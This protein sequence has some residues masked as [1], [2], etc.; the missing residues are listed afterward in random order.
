[1]GDS[2]FFKVDDDI[3]QAMFSHKFENI[4]VFHVSEH[5]Y[6]TLYKAERMGKWFMLKALK[7]EFA[8]SQLY[9][10][11]LYKEFEIGYN[12]SHPNIV[13]TLGM[14]N[15]PECGGACI[16]LEYIDGFNLRDYMTHGDKLTDETC[17]NII[18]EMSRALE[19]IHERQIIHRDLKPE[20][21]LITANGH[22]VKLI[23]FGFADVD[24]YSVLKASAGTRKYAAPEQLM[25]GAVVDSRAD[26][27]ALGLIMQEL[28]Q[29]VPALGKVARRCCNVNPARRPQRARYVPL[30]V[31]RLRWRRWLRAIAFAV[32][33]PVVIAITLYLIFSNNVKHSMQ[34]VVEDKT[35][36]GDTLRLSQ[37][38]DSAFDSRIDTPLT[39][40]PIKET[41][42]VSAGNLHPVDSVIGRVPSAEE[43]LGK[44]YA[45]TEYPYADDP[46][47]GSARSDATQQVIP[48]VCEYVLDVVRQISEAGNV[49]ELEQVLAKCKAQG[50][51]RAQLQGKVHR[52]L[53][54]QVT[55]DGEQEYA[56][57]YH[58]KADYIIDEKYNELRMLHRPL[59]ESKIAEIYK[60]AQ[61]LSLDEQTYRIASV[62]SFHRYIDYLTL[63]DTLTTE[64]SYTKAHIGYWRHLTKVDAEQWLTERVAKQSALYKQ[65]WDIVLS[66]ISNLE[67]AYEIVGDKR[68]AEAHSH[69]DGNF[70]VVTKITET[71]DN[72]YIKE[73]QL[74]EDGEWTY[75]VYDPIT[76]EMIEKE[77]IIG[78][79]SP[80]DSDYDQLLDF[81]LNQ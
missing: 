22:H 49:E 44:P 63:C 23:D 78:D 43:F 32:A 71:L 39:L 70:V 55:A 66:T 58:K 36:Q 33:L 17:V 34:Q 20:N 61:T 18:D 1:M 2:G 73:A 6:S 21:I 50:G 60:S 28:A 45:L 41:E 27:Y 24:S 25:P 37:T 64:A 8:D 13:Q 67:K 57:F 40:Q 72:G 26:I 62:M 14:E 4:T 47:L 59:V 69:L 30:L 75:H 15:V 48:M 12:L 11:L 9:K 81:E 53:T 51:L 31:A 77:G 10:A 19:Y 38:T 42:S 54:K 80:L 5:G 16:V 52:W 3:G 7:P 68:L 76:I 35:L 79:D 56:A 46:F 65:C 29:Y 74:G